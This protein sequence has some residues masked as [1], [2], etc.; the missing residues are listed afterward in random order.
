MVSFPYKIYYR[1]VKQLPIND[2]ES[3]FVRYNFYFERRNIVFGSFLSI[4]HLH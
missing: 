4:F 2:L 1:P 3:K